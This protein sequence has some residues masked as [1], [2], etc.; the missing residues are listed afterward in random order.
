MVAETECLSVA[1]HLIELCCQAIETLGVNPVVHVEL[2]GCAGLKATQA[3]N[4]AEVNQAFRQNGILAE[5]KPEYWRGQWEYASTFSRQPPL[6]VA[7]D[8]VKALPLLPALFRKQQIE[9]TMMRPVVWHGDLGRMAG[10]SRSIRT[11]RGDAIH[12]PNGVQ[13]NI[14]GWDLQGR[15]LVAETSLGESLQCSLLQSSYENCLLFLPEEEAF[16]RLR[17][18]SWYQLHREL[19]SPHDLSGGHQGSIALYRETGKHNQPLGMHPL[20][21]DETEQPLRA[22]QRWKHSARVEH[23]L[24]A[25]SCHYD[26]HLNVL[27][28]LLNLKDAILKPERPTGRYQREL[29]KSLYDQ[30]EAIGAI[31]LFR[32][33]RWLESRVNELLRWASATGIDTTL[34]EHCA[35]KLKGTVLGRYTPAIINSESGEHPS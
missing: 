10:K 28:A 35:Q 2:E 17:L 29:P 25:S 27:F 32:Q 4:F 8:L 11:A 16:E 7:D 33:S 21:L 9:K 31:S 30:K 13:L 1:R 5:L 14:S 18:K 23:R 34:D 6:R 19:N 24:G 3:I 22:E 15:N 26:V 20:L 12:I